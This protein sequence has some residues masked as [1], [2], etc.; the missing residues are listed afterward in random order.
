MSGL[1]ESKL[2]YRFGSK[3]F[4]VYQEITVS[5]KINRNYSEKVEKGLVKRG[6]KSAKT[7]IYRNSFVL[8]YYPKKISL[9][10]IKKYLKNMGYTITSYD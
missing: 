4:Q 7:D 5:P 1:S 9:N 3:K 2:F 10:K 8:R 6:V